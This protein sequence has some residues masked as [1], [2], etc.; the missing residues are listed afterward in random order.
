MQKR[1]LLDKTGCPP[2]TFTDWV[3]RG[4]VV[5][6]EPGQGKGTHAV[7]DESNAAA[8]LVALRMKEGGVVVVNYVA[9][10]E[11]LHAWL[12]STS[13][14]EWHRY[15][16]A[17]TPGGIDVQPVKKMMNLEDMA[18]VVPMAPICRVL[19]A[20]IEGST[21]LPIFGLHAAK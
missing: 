13:S 1:D 16:V 11:A 5:P 4:I 8:L 9:A 20:N 17:M 21:Q 15:I 14:F 3:A 18:L 2:P 6:A 19:A 7:Y 10:F 12:R